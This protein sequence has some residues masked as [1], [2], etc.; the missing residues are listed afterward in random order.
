LILEGDFVY[1]REELRRLGVEPL[2]AW[3]VSDQEM[4]STKPIAGLAALK[5]LKTRVI[6]REWPQLI[7]KFDGTP[8]AMSWA[9]VYEALSRGTIDANVGF[10][11]ANTTSKLYEVAKHHT[12]IN[13]GA[14]AGPLAIINKRTWDSLP[15]DI[16]QAMREAS[17]AYVDKLADIY[18]EEYQEDITEMKANGVR[19]YKWSSG[20]RAKLQV[21]MENLWE[22]WANKMA[23]KN[24]PGREA[25]RR[26]IE[27]QEKYSR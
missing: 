20:D 24:I 15:K 14:P 23:D 26:Y 12:Q 21:A 18:E 7:S 16:Q 10:V 13:L 8:V 6:G 22:K 17:R 1:F 27:L 5:G 2:Y 4:I 9:E 19:F 11:A 3:G 25:L